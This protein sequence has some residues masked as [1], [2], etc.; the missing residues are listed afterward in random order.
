MPDGLGPVR[1]APE[2]CAHGVAEDGHRR[3]PVPG[4]SAAPADPAHSK[5]P[6]RRRRRHRRLPGRVPR[7]SRPRRTRVVAQHLAHAAGPTPRLP[8]S[9]FDV[10]NGSAHTAGNLDLQE[11]ILTPIGDPNLPE[12]VRGDAEVRKAR[13]TSS[14]RSTRAVPPAGRHKVARGLAPPGT[15]LS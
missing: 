3:R 4:T 2:I 7:R 5:A 9:H 15:E 8:V 10:V 11:F 12:A 14:S 13:S 6:A 1:T